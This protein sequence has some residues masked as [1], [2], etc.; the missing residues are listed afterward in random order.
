MWGVITLRSKFILVLRAN[1]KVNIFLLGEEPV[2][3][4]L[5]S[6]L[7]WGCIWRRC[8]SL[9]LSIPKFDWSQSISPNNES[10]FVILW[11]RS[12]WVQLYLRSF[13]DVVFA[14]SPGPQCVT[15]FVLLAWCLLWYTPAPLHP[16]CGVSGCS[17]NINVSILHVFKSK[18]FI[19]LVFIRL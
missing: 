4:C 10:D 15:A 7:W 18:T 2:R 16:K 3:S 13:L 14:C 19:H 11:T 6:S 9:S 17:W 1:I 8:G 5:G 12:L